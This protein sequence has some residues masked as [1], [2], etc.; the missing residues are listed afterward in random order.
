MV[1]GLV[2]LRGP[3]ALMPTKARSADARKACRYFFPMF[4]RALALFLPTV[5]GDCANSTIPL[6]VIALSILVEPARI[7]LVRS[8][9]SSLASSPSVSPSSW[10][11]SK[12]IEPTDQ[13]PI[14]TFNEGVLLRQIAQRKVS[15]RRT[16]LAGTTYQDKFSD[17]PNR[18]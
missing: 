11:G 15:L 14:V 2:L 18:I 16:L 13:H 8:S 12:S 7:A 3:V 10:S 6:M 4:R 1:I 9:A 5:K 17:L